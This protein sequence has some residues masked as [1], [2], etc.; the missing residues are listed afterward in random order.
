MSLKKSCFFTVRNIS[1]HQ[2]RYLCFFST[3]SLF[4]AF[5]AIVWK[6]IKS[7]SNHKTSFSE[8][9]TIFSI[10]HAVGKKHPIDSSQYKYESFSRDETT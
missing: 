7:F 10:Q 8:K 2:S 3:K 4:H 9:K 6:K 5:R 1:F